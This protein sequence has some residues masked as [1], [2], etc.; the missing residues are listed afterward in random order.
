MCRLFH[1]VSFRLKITWAASSETL[2]KVRKKYK[3]NH[4]AHAQSHPG[5]C[6]PLIHSIVSNGSISGQ[7]RPCLDCADAQAELGLRCPH[8]PDES[9]SNDEAHIGC[10]SYVEC[11]ETRKQN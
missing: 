10:S 3:F 9:F 11:M 1:F 4:P 7:Q 6:S 8:M 5:I 2:S